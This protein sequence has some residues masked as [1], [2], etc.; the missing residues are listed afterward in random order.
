MKLIVI[1]NE[2]LKVLMLL[3]KIILPPFALLSLFL[4]FDIDVGY[5]VLFLV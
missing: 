5:H 1:N 2:F 3:V 4:I